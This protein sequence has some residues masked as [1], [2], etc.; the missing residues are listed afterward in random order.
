MGFSK[1][2]L[3]KLNEEIERYDLLTRLNSIEKKLNQL[4]EDLKNLINIYKKEL[5]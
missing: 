2:Y 3:K 5:K 4:E 1:R